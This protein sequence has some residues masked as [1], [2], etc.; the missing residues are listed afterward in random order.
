MKT[1][2]VII[3]P[4]L[5]PR[6]PNWLILAPTKVLASIIGVFASTEDKINT[7]K[8]VLNEPKSILLTSLGIKPNIL[9]IKT[10]NHW[11]FALILSIFLTLGYLEDLSRGQKA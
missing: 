2:M 3:I 7:L 10:K 4:I 11:F 5:I 6:L 9:T 1:N 8:S